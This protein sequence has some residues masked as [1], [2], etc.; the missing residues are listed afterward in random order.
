MA[1]IPYLSSLKF[2]AAAD[3]IKGISRLPYHDDFAQDLI[4]KALDERSKAPLLKGQLPRAERAQS[5]LYA[6]QSN[7][8]ALK[9]AIPFISDK[10]P[11]EDDYHGKRRLHFPASRQVSV[12]LPTYLSPNSTA[13]PKT[14]TTR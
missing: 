13:M 7:S 2:I 9:R 12:Y 8:K 14:I 10:D 1:R 3:S 5:M 4:E 6:A 11:K